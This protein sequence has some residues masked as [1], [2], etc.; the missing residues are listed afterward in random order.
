MRQLRVVVATDR[1]GD[2]DSAAAGA[3]LA[4]GFAEHAQVAVVPLAAGGPD[5]ARAVAA[6][7]G[8]RVDLHVDRW[9]V[10]AGDTLLVGLRQQ[11]G[12]AWRPGATTTDFGE[13]LDRC[14]AGCDA[15]EVVLDLTGLSAHDGG[16]GLLAVAGPRLAGRSVL[17]VV[18]AGELEVPATGIGGGLA[19]RAF[20]ER[21]DVAEL[22]RA[23][24]ELTAYADRLGAGLATAPGGGAAGTVGLA[25]LANGGELLTGTQ[26]CHRLSGLARTLPLAD[27]VVTGCTELTPLDRGG[28]VVTA[29]SDWAGAAERPCIVFTTATGLARRE[30]RTLG[31]ESA[32]V[33]GP[34]PVTAELLTAAAA[35]IAAGWLPGAPN[36]NVD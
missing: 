32:H 36:R 17:G 6:I 23:D 33:V 34:A 13:W 24:A 26:F 14:L 35:R 20:T 22:L 21:V 29:V 19:R 11:S 28:D 30:L 8:A 10:R 7:S 5:L 3:A 4:R 2:L 27:L 16:A 9:Q 15:S 1:I 25:V 12:A 31:V 18:A